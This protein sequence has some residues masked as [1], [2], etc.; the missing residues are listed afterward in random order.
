MG[1]TEINFLLFIGRLFHD[2]KNKENQFSREPESIFQNVTHPLAGKKKKKKVSD[3]K[4][5]G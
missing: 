1:S 2:I 4:Q 3:E 5:I